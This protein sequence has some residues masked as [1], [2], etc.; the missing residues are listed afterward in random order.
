MTDK[1][2]GSKENSTMEQIK[3]RFYKTPH[4]AKLKLAIDKIYNDYI[5]G[6]ENAM[7][8]GEEYIAWT[9]ETLIDQITKA[10]LSETN[11]L[12]LEDTWEVLEAKHVRFM[13]EKRVREIVEHRVQVRHSKE[14]KWAWEK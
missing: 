11:Y 2:E 13:G 1:E 3:E 9:E 8:D 14:G 4:E 7:M 6:D 12:E 5:G 10:I